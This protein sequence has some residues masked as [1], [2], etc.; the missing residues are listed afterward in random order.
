MH[1]QKCNAVF[2]EVEKC[3]ERTSFL[4]FYIPETRLLLST[5]NL[6]ISHSLHKR[7]VQVFAFA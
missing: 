4:L 3:G 2:Y 5:Q 1:S 6:N 7:S